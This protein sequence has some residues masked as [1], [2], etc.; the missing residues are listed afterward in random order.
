[1]QTLVKAAQQ[2]LG[3]DQNQ[4]MQFILKF[5]LY[6]DRLE[7]QIYKSIEPTLEQFIMELTKT[8]KF[9]QTRYPSVPI[10]TA[11]LTGYGVSVPAFNDFVSTKTG[12]Q[13]IAGNPWQRVHAG[14]DLQQTLLQLAPKFAVAV[15]LAE[16]NS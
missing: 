2:N 9:F 5:G 10:Q 7:G 11:I 6:P 8:I 15:G 16:R 13:A 3:I 14:G 1:M 12:L 4:A